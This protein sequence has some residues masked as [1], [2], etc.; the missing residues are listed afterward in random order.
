MEAKT[1][2]TSSFCT[3]RR[4]SPTRWSAPGASSTKKARS[5][6][7][8][9]PPARLICSTS[10]SAACRDGTPKT[11][12]GPER[13]VVM[14]ISQ[15]ARLASLGAGAL[16]SRPQQRAG[17][18]GGAEHR[19]AAGQ[20]GR[21]AHRSR[22]LSSWSGVAPRLPPAWPGAAPEQRGGWRCRERRGAPRV[23]P[24]PERGV[25]ILSIQSWVAFGHVGNASA[26]FPLQRL[27]AEVWA[28]NTVQF[29]NHTGYGS[30]RGQVFPAVAGPRLRRR[31][32][33]ARRPAAVRRGAVRLHGRRRDR[34]GDL[35][36]R[37]PRAGRQRQGRVVLRPGDRRRR[38]RR[39]RAPGHPGVLPRPGAAR[40]RH[41]HAEPVRAGMAYRAARSAASRKPRPPCSAC[42][43]AGRAACWSPR[44]T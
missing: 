6:T 23:A 15:L 26:V 39:L 25:N 32:R 36:R 12:A 38:A 20:L 35:R 44:S 8:P 11:E 24:A 43:R 2:C 37:G 33:G 13:K 4:Y 40:R 14:P 5:G 9:M 28:I 41:R 27:G 17:R 16:A 34:R 31:H 30:W 29:S 21:L 10:S 3:R 22:I 42:R 1:T 19:G 18:G 7:P